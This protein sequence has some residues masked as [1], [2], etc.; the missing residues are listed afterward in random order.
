VDGTHVEDHVVV[1]GVERL[2]E[3]AVPALVQR[4]EDGLVDAHVCA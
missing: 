4:P 2:D 1:L 3:R